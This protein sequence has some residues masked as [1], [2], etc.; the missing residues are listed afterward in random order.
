MDM[1]FFNIKK[2]RKKKR[3]SM[4][5]R[6]ILWVMVVMMLVIGKEW[7]SINGCLDHERIALLQLPPLFN[8]SHNLLDWG[9]KSNCCEWERVVCENS[10]K[11]VI[12]LHISNLRDYSLTEEWY[13]NLTM[14]LPFQKLQFLSLSGNNI[15]GFVQDKGFESGRSKLSN[16]EFLDLSANNLN[17]SVLTFLRALPSLIFLGLR[18]NGLGGT[19]H[20][21]DTLVNLEELDISRNSIKEFVAPNDDKSLSNLKVLSMEG[22]GTDKIKLLQSMGSLLFLKTLNLRT[23]IFN[24]TATTLR[25][26]NL[27]NV[28]ELVLDDSTVHT[29]IFQSLDGLTS[30]KNLS[31]VGTQFNGKFAA[32]DLPNFKNLEVLNMSYSSILNTD[33]FLQSID[34][35]ALKILVLRSSGL[36]GIMSVA[37]G[38]CRLRRLE[39]LDLSNNDLVGNLPKCLSNLTYLRTLDLSYNQFTEDL[40]ESPIISL[41]SIQELSLL[42]NNFK[43]PISLGPFFNF[44]GLKIFRGDNNSI[45]DDDLEL[46]RSLFPKFQLNTISLSG[47]YANV[48]PAFPKFLYYQHDLEHVSIY[49]VSMKGEFPHWLL[50]NNTRLKV[51]DLGSNSL[52]RFPNFSND[53]KSY[54]EL[55]DLSNN[56]IYGDIP[57]DFGAYFQNLKDLSMA[58]NQI[59]GKIPPSVGD[60]SALEIMDLSD[61]KLFGEIPKL[62]GIGCL[63]LHTLVL[64]GNSLEG[65]LLFPDLNL[66]ELRSLRL[67]GNKFSGKIPDSLTNSPFLA[68]LDL[69][70]N[71]FSGHIPKWMGSMTSL[72][73]LRL[74]NNNLEGQIPVEFCQLQ[75]LEILDLSENSI[76][77]SIPSC[78]S[79]PGLLMVRLSKNKLQGTLT[80]AFSSSPALLLIDLSNNRLTGSFPDWIGGLFELSYLLLNDNYF[81]GELPYTFCML[82]QL[83]LINLSQNNFTGTIPDCLYI[84]P[85]GGIYFPIDK[86]SV[87][88]PTKRM[89]YNY[90]GELLYM[91]SGIDLSC[92]NFLGHIP[93]NIG[94]L[95]EIHALNLS[96]NNLSGPIPAT[97][98]NLKQVESLDLSN[99]LLIGNIP[100]MLGGLS[101]LAIFSVANNNLSGQVPTTPHF[102]TFNESSFQGNP[103]LCG[104]PLPRSCLSRPAMPRALD[105]S[106]EEDGGFMDMR[107]FYGSLIA[108]Y[109]ITLL[110]F[111]MVLLINPYWRQL[112]F[113]HIEK[114][115]T[116]SY[117]FF[118]DS[119]HK[120]LVFLWKPMS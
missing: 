88:F 53:Y 73:D 83:S 5:L 51:L 91:M 16:L 15:A 72:V 79:P 7:K 22:V 33:E 54:L 118:V 27:P 55:L 108:T 117:Y 102:T 6:A 74:Q 18:Y 41:T 65:D 49:N 3:K 38:L 84:S 61:N 99:N 95:T 116:S 24:K 58:S 4:E 37:K 11:R 13:V 107:Y 25:L 42:E 12:E 98:G 112:L 21:Q 93:P 75:N 105:N 19:V 56:L 29:S 67:D 10:T 2:K 39:V 40:A 34:M 17:N 96:H 76:S 66:T 92:N 86:G 57:M 26:H 115:T 9:E 32:G 81:G 46:A 104:K 35:N 14:F 100:P 120:M 80:N 43:I 103:L 63:A 48:G 28:E 77:G 114:W 60:M 70:K 20:I 109:G 8:N 110:G 71:N 23:N 94:N 30:L 1:L 101:S 97:F 31:L 68:I 85:G 111:V 44:T 52:S 50:K 89:S 87:E 78:F 59:R 113:Y 62:L 36:N 119:F 64:S 82:D 106:T 90:G 69:S 47:Y 45:Y